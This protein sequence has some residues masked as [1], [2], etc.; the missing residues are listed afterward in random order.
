MTNRKKEVIKNAHRL[1]LDKGFHATSIQ[2]IL[3]YSGI[4]K[5]TFYNYFSSKNELLIDLIKTIYLGLDK[6]RNELLIGQ[7]RSDISIF[8]KQIELQIATNRKYNLLPLFE[9]V[10]ASGDEEL[11]QFIKRGQLRNINWKYE[12]FVELFGEDKKTYLLD[13]A[14]MFTGMLQQNLRYYRMAYGPNGDAEPVVRYCVERI[15][16]LVEHVADTGDQLLDPSMLHV[17]IPKE[18][19]GD[20]QIQQ[21]LSETIFVLKKK[22]VNN[23]ENAK[24]LELVEFLHDELLQTKHPRKFLIESCLLSLKQGKTSI[25]KKDLQQLEVLI[26][27]FL[28]M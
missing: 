24:Y 26:E 13:C 5:G 9:E 28:S 2:D 11:K 20:R 4:S 6:S 17:W 22:L 7:D 23:G 15:A 12:R 25:E 8:R 27:N 14:I 18:N 19:N 16:H 10:S 21:E 3:E 1:F